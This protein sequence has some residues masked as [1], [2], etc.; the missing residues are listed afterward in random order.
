MRRRLRFHSP[1]KQLVK[2]ELRFSKEKTKF[3]IENKRNAVNWI[4]QIIIVCIIAFV[5]VW[6]L[7]QRIS[8][9]GDSMNPVLKNGDIVL[10]NRVVYN[11]SKPKRNDIIVFKPN[12]NENMH[13]YIKRIIGL[14]GE[15]VEI[16]EGAV[17]IDEELLEESFTTTAITDAGIA[18]E[19]IELAGDEYFVLGDNR[20]AS[21]D[22]R[23]ADVGNVKRADIYGKAWFIVSPA[24][25]F[26]FIKE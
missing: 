8:N 10:V 14:P 11:A 12:G 4:V 18:N 7:G 3:E 20:A 9:V 24:A 6:F 5:C 19:K 26:G 23:M 21:E 2:G 15:T 1:E 13:Y 22:S 25:A 16:K 17:Y